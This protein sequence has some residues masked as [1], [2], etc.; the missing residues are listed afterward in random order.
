MRARSRDAEGNGHKSGVRLKLSHK[1]S[2]I[3]IAVGVV[4]A[5]A[6]GFVAY[7]GAKGSLRAEAEAKLSAVLEARHEPLAA[8]LQSIRSDLR[9]QA[10]NPVTRT[11]LSAFVSSWRRLGRHRPA[12]TY[13]DSLL[14]YLD[15]PA[16]C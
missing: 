10:E 1:V 3:V 7:L 9:A 4:S 15:N 2:L 16:Q 6:V 14:I 8:Y 12:L 13:G 11:A 5:L